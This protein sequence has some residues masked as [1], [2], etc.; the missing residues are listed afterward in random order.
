MREIDTTAA[1]NADFTEGVESVIY[2]R[3]ME[4]REVPQYNTAEISGAEC[5]A[6]EAERWR[7]AVAR[8]FASLGKGH[9]GIDSCP[10]CFDELRALVPTEATS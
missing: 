7:Q 6:C 3:C 8:M 5:A 9:S 10:E 2:I 4:H 1:R